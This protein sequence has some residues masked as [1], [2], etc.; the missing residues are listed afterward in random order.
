[1]QKETKSKPSSLLKRN[2]KVSPIPPEK[3]SPG[4]GQHITSDRSGSVGPSCRFW[5]SKRLLGW[6]CSAVLSLQAVQPG[7]WPRS[8][9]FLHKHHTLHLE[10]LP[11][12]APRSWPCGYHP[13]ITCWCCH[14]PQPCTKMKGEPRQQEC[15]VK[16]R[17]RSSKPQFPREGRK[18]WTAGR[19]CGYP[20]LPGPSSPFTQ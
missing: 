20:V 17:P 6:G 13:S 18:H 5:P 8:G 3:T 11:W 19:T 14:K 9:W 4:P 12:G 15:L 16:L 1:M 7:I 10:V 2:P